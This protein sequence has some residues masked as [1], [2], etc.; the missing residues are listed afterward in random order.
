MHLV[1]L[2]A[3]K[4]V[5][6]NTLVFFLEKP[7]NF[8]F[9]PGQFIT[10]YLKNNL[11]HDF[12]IASSPKEKE[13]IIATRMRDSSFKKLLGKIKV[14]DKIKIE[15]SSGQFILHKNKKNPAVFL[16]G[17]IGITPFRSMIKNFPNRK[18]TLFYSN[19]KTEDA[20][21]LDE[22]KELENKNLKL[23]A[24]MTKEKG[25]HINPKMIKENVKDWRR[26]IYYAVGSTGFVQFIADMLAKMK[27]KSENIKTENFSGY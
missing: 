4:E 22:L 24:T 21:F 23:V 14:G 10:L 15:G 6:E 3:K 19:R 17:G 18:I 13:L 27:I 8:K 20:A 16:A 1:K 2:L 25:K 11:A 7:K 26:V 5:A 12:S 9:V